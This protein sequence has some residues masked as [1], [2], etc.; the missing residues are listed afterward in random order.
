M[1][2][3]VTRSEAISTLP[4]PQ[5]ITWPTFSEQS[6][7]RMKIEIPRFSF[8]RSFPIVDFVPAGLSG[9]ARMVLEIDHGV[10]AVLTLI[11]STTNGNDNFQVEQL[12]V[13]MET[14]VHR[15]LADFVACSFTAMFGFGGATRIEI[16]AAAFSPVAN[17]EADLLGLSHILERRRVAH[18]I[19]TIERATNREFELPK[20]INSDEMENIA[21]SFY[22]LRYGSFEWPIPSITAFIPASN[23]GLTLVQTLNKMNPVRLG[24]DLHTVELF[25]QH[26]S[27]GEAIVTVFDPVIDNLSGIEQEVAAND[28]H[29]VSVLVRSKSNKGHYD[30][31]RGPQSFTYKWEPFIDQLLRMEE[32]FDLHLAD[33]Y[34]NLATST[35]EGLSETLK[36]ELTVMPTL[37]GNAFQ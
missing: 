11:G 22:A 2:V 32:A 30:F 31:V 8:N 10:R 6:A 26:F 14:T 33:S 20:D 12:S 5:L 3:L 13:K 7:P 23:E 36:L 4:K 24:P 1:T 27:L 28:G 37:E 9:T 25:N 17:F 18:R 15:A 19:M 16:P 34:N 29:L 21:R 35:L